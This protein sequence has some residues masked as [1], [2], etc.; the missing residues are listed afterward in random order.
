MLTVKYEDSVADF[1]RT[2]HTTKGWRLQSTSESVRLLGTSHSSRMILVVS[3]EAPSSNR[4]RPT[5]SPG[6]FSNAQRIAGSCS[7]HSLVS[8]DLRRLQA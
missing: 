7:I 6:G 3:G 1:T 8:T 5:R 2:H 4:S